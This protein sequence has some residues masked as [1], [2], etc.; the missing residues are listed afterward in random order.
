MR[1]GRRPSLGWQTYRGSSSNRRR[2]RRRRGSDHRA[3]ATTER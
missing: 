2:R 1:A 3:L